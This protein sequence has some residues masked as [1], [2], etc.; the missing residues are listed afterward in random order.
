MNLGR[1][2]ANAGSEADSCRARARFAPPSPNPCFPNP[3]VLHA[4]L[5]EYV[6]VFGSPIGTEGHSGRFL[7]DDYFHI[8]YGEQWAYSPGQLVKEV[9]RPGDQHLMRKGVAKGYK[10]PETCWALEYARGNIVAMMPFG[11]ADTF[12]STLDFITL[13][14]TIK[15][16]GGN[17]IKALMKGKI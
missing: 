11:I 15:A 5:S 6:I 8:L 13:W 10:I 7:S 14:Q 2:N 17:M 16:S 9:Y 4:S 12:T 3:Q 1:W